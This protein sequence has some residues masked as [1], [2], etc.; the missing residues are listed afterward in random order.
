MYDSLLSEC[1]CAKK[2]M[3]KSQFFKERL[4]GTPPTHSSKLSQSVSDFSALIEIDSLKLFLGQ[5]GC[6]T[7]GT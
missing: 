4:G 1:E 7:L 3:L 6:T 2:F 5:E